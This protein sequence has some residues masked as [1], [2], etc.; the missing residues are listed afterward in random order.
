M[1]EGEGVDV[2]CS[3]HCICAAKIVKDVGIDAYVKCF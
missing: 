2:S 1:P 3:F